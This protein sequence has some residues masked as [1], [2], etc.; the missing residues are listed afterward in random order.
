M[1]QDTSELQPDWDLTPGQSPFFFGIP[2]ILLLV[3]AAIALPR[4][5]KHRSLF[6]QARDSV[7]PE[8]MLSPG[9]CVIEGVVEYERDAALAV[10]VELEQVGEESE[11]SGSWSHSWTE[12]G[13]SV[14]VH[15]FL[16][17]HASGQ[18][19]RVE[20]TSE[21][22]LIDEMDGVV[23]VDLTHRTR[24]AELVPGER[25]F[26]E[27]VLSQDS[28]ARGAGPYRSGKGWV[29]RAPASRP[30]LLSSEPMGERFL[31][32]AELHRRHGLLAAF[33]L[34]ML[35]LFNIDYVLL[36]CRGRVGE[37]TVTNLVFKQNKDSEGSGR[38]Y[39]Y[40]DLEAPELGIRR[41]ETVSEEGFRKL[42]KGKR[43]PIR[44]VPGVP[45]LAELGPDPTA[46]GFR[47]LGFLA[48]SIVLLIVYRLRVGAMRAWYEFKVINTG[49]GT[50][51]EHWDSVMS[52]HRNKQA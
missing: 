15:P 6:L 17:K 51:Q 32:R 37:A 42:K 35:P 27:G 14:Q 49:S 13:R 25:V 7:S 48:A 38:N 46:S 52:S 30:M 19:I 22:L 9:A 11:H 3:I 26:A 41:T 45:W 47:T 44:Y 28:G 5:R 31:R 1:P 21:V 23:M 10:R 8:A 12:V 16:L 24:V 43:A 34:L 33:L 36:V 18:T 2:L 50:L 20:P 29:L 4:W 40:A 39:G